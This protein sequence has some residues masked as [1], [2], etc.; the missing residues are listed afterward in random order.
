MN[1]AAGS[2]Q[3]FEILLLVILFEGIT[4]LAKNGDK[5]ALFPHN[6]HN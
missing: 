4:S 2:L 5:I 3:V 1:A 6:L